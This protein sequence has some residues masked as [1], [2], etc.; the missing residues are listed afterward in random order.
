MQLNN[1]IEIG[2]VTAVQINTVH[3]DLDSS[4]YTWVIRP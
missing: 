2:P 3:V 4:M 1:P